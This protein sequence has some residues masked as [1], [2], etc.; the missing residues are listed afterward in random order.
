MKFQVSRKKE[1]E[2]SLTFQNFP[3]LD[4]FGIFEWDFLEG[5][6]VKSGQY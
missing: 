5:F 2:T 4:T 3:Y 6:A 1:E